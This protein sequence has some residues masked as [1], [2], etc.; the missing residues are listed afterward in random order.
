M[1]K[2]ISLLIAIIMLS[3]CYSQES[4]KVS[5]FGLG[6]DFNMQYSFFN[7][8]TQNGTAIPNDIFG[9]DLIV[10]ISGHNRIGYKT[11]LN[12]AINA[13]F[14]GYI[15][16]LIGEDDALY[17]E[18]GLTYI[19]L[20]ITVTYNLLTGKDKFDTN[21]RSITPSGLTITMG[22]YYSFLNRININDDPNSNF[23]AIVKIGFGFLG[24]LDF[25]TNI[26]LQRDLSSFLGNNYDD[27][28]RTRITLGITIPMFTN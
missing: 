20:P 2:S 9:L 11:V 6:F 15:F 16:S 12:Y 7:E 28:K 10:G 17:N 22:G 1:K 26:T 5:N 24:A 19:E 25:D 18:E 4:K 21:K 8:P 3:N 13:P 14:F 23:G 27:F